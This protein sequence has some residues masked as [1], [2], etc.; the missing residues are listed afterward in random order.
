M[1]LLSRRGEFVRVTGLAG[2]RLLALRGSTPFQLSHAK[3]YEPPLRKVGRPRVRDYSAAESRFNIGSPVH[4]L[5]DI[6]RRVSNPKNDSEYTRINSKIDNF[7]RANLGVQNVM[8]SLT[9]AP[10]SFPADSIFR[11]R[12]RTIF[13]FVIR[14]VTKNAKYIYIQ[15]KNSCKF[16]N[17]ATTYLRRHFLEP[18]T[19]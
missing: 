5:R 4:F 8:N 10:L 16:W 14:Y 2:P 12:L 11:I 17:T 1:P 18:Q 7:G 15:Q 9:A 13:K 19:R 3:Y 6:R